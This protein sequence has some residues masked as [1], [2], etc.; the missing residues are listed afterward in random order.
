[1]V[2]LACGEMSRN[3]EKFEASKHNMGRSMGRRIE[4]KGTVGEEKESR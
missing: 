2:A 1:M 3:E 4:E